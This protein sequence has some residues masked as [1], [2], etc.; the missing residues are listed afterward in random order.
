[1]TPTCAWAQADD[2]RADA[3]ERRQLA[4]SANAG[5]EYD[6]NAL[7]L[8]GAEASG[9]FLTRYLL[10]I[11]GIMRRDQDTL[12]LTFGQGGKLFY[13]EQ[14]ADTLLTQLALGWRHRLT[15]RHEVG[16]SLDLKDRTERRS[17]QD[18][19]RGGAGLM[20]RHRF[21]RFQLDAQAGWRYFAYKPNPSASSWGPGAGGGVN[22]ELPA[23]LGARLSYQ[24]LSR[25]FESARR[26]QP[27]GQTMSVVIDETQTRQDTFQALSAHASW[28][29][30]VLLDAGYTYSQNTSNS[31]GQNLARHNLSAT[32]NAPLPLNLFASLK[33]D[34]QRTAY[35]DAVFLDANFRVDEDNRNALVVAM[36]RPLGEHWEVEARYSYYA[37]EFGAGEDYARQTL[38]LGLGY[39]LETQT[40]D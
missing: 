4:L 36:G 14:D 34:L 30:P 7:R 31:Y 33:L 27:D 1:M 5:L 39:A 18:Y 19:N 22:L 37:Q 35:E 12:L 15:G 13:R 11:D 2:V 32:L 29:G 10:S 9:D 26:V 23:G 24:W 25:G 8:T 6:N 28:R 16:F 17:L 3:L 21:W 20:S 40:H 38:Q